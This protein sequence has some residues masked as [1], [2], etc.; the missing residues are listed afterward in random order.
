MK[1]EVRMKDREQMLED[2]REAIQNG[3]A[4]AAKKLIE[5]ALEEGVEGQEIID[6]CLLKA[7]DQIAEAFS[8]D[9][10]FVPDVILASR[11]MNV[12]TVVVEEAMEAEMT[13]TMGRVVTATVR[14]DLHDIGLNLVSMML[15][16]VGFQVYNMGCDVSA[17]A[18]IK[19]AEEIQA[20]IICMSAMLTTTMPQIQG[21]I[22]LLENKGL[23]NKYCIMIGGAPVTGRFAH[24]IGADI[25]TAD[26]GEA[27]VEARKWMLENRRQKEADEY[28]INRN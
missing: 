25:Y 17:D 7:M 22:K 27:A 12:A 5:Q 24:R 14:G 6:R 2:I 20:D 21:V 11:A 19:K 16:N 10:K 13:G 8:S 18:L 26:A 1:K 4:K 28:F 15:R 9:L 3:K 23:R